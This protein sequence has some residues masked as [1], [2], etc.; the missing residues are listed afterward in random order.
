MNDP[1]QSWEPGVPCCRGHGNALGR[2][3]RAARAGAPAR[4]GEGSPYNGDLVPPSGSGRSSY[5]P[6][7]P[8]PDAA[9]RCSRPRATR[10]GW[11]G[12]GERT[13]ER[14]ASPLAGWRATNEDD[15]GGG[16]GLADGWEPRPPGTRAPGCA[17]PP[18]PA[19]APR[20]VA[21]P[22]P[23]AGGGR[24]SPARP[25]RL[26]AARWR[27][28]TGRCCER[29]GG[30]GRGGGGRR[31]Y[32]TRPVGAAGGHWCRLDPVEPESR[33][34]GPPRTEGRQQTAA[35]PRAHRQP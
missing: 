26:E 5:A 21:I 24:A 19:P 12:M 33:R 1:T 11:D 9:R 29:E 10:M 34:P 30:Q 18:A 32:E 22:A 7:V 2:S 13:N 27:M 8:P 6:V 25:A 15:S 17:A 31:S 23:A 3:L 14:R 20:L 4:A 28:A 16:G 35:W